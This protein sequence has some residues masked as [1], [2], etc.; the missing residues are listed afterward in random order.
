MRAF[1]DKGSICFSPFSF[2]RSFDG[3]RFS[4]AGVEWGA[5]HFQ[6]KF[7][8][9]WKSKKSEQKHEEP[10]IKWTPRHNDALTIRDRETGTVEMDETNVKRT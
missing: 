10:Y 4:G 5:Q 2:V 8:L 9:K 6:L 1:I 7:T 3:Y